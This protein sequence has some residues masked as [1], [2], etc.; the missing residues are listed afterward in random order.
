MD[1]NTTP[2]IANPDDPLRPLLLRLLK[3]PDDA[4]DA[5]VAFGAALFNAKGHPLQSTGGA[6]DP[7]RFLL[8]D[9]LKL[10]MDCSDQH[11]SDAF[12]ALVEAMDESGSSG[13]RFFHR[14]GGRLQLNNAEDSIRR[15]LGFTRLQWAMLR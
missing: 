9:I 4:R 1:T 15:Q 2:L 8:C 3:L 10:P 5:R 14:Q 7:W 6:D 12:A 11:L 13:P